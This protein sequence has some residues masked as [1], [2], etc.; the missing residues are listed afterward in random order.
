MRVHPHYMYLLHTIRCRE[1]V[2]KVELTYLARFTPALF[3]LRIVEVGARHV[4]VIS[5]R[6]GIRSLVEV[7]LS[8]LARRHSA[9]VWVITIV[10]DFTVPRAFIG[11][12]LRLPLEQAGEG[13]W[14]DHG[15]PSVCGASCGRCACRSYECSMKKIC[16]T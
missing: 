8:R 1:R 12:Y 15:K 16:L 6:A 11:A 7:L 4:E 3:V 13:I 9:A 14:V 2:T 10:Y 5:R